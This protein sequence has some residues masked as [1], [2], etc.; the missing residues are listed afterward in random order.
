[1]TK[2]PTLKAL[3]EGKAGECRGLAI[4]MRAEA[5]SQGLGK[6]HERILMERWAEALN[7]I[8]DGLT[9]AVNAGD[10]QR[11]RYFI[12][13]VAAVGL[14]VVSGAAGGAAQSGT[15]G[16]FESESVQAG[17]NVVLVGLSELEAETY[18][19]F[20][21]GTGVIGVANIT[22]R[23]DVAE[24]VGITDSVTVELANVETG[25][26]TTTT[27]SDPARPTPER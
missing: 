22:E 26:I 21:V 4:A 20:A 9:E 6:R 18:E 13:A 17:A 1:M 10:N 25:E 2:R 15:V 7:A 14:A 27:S 24:G 19:V 11:L 16:I 3:V 5:E 23:P 8:S 12:N